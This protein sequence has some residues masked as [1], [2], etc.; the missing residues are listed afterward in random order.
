MFLLNYYQ[1]SK[2]EPGSQDMDQLIC[3]MDW[4]TVREYFYSTIFCY[5]I[6]FIDVR[7]MSDYL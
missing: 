7:Q 1:I 6:L 5:Q 3:A 4:G 2:N